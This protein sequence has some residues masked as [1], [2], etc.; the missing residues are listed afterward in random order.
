MWEISANKCFV[1]FPGALRD[2]RVREDVDFRPSVGILTVPALVR[3]LEEGF[4]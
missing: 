4:A 1:G 3:L 2:P